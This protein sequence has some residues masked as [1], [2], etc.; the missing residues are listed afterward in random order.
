MGEIK[1]SDISEIGIQEKLGFQEIKP[2]EGMTISESNDFWN[3]EVSSL[4]SS[5]EK[6]EFGG[7]YNLEKARLDI[8]PLKESNKGSFEGER[9]NS[10][11][12]PSS[13]TEK[14]Q[15]C[16]EKLAEYGKDGI[17]YKNL[18]PDFSEV[19]EATVKI[20]NMTEHRLDYIDSDWNS[21]L[22]N[23]SQADIKCAELWNSQKRDG[24][25]DWTDEDVYNFRHQPEHRYSW[26][27]RCDTKTMD[28][29][30][31]EIHSYCTHLGGC[32]ECRVRDSGD[33]GGEFDE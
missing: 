29:V 32:S 20:D 10:K 6:T 5:P 9:G 12:I 23:F 21:K 11:F 28:L 31:Y 19:A 18:E 24:H 8:I 4:D 25:T 3:K 13:E 17:E 1:I 7:K 30:P 15:A 2:K 22:G 16:K 33:F 27:E 14:G 26:H